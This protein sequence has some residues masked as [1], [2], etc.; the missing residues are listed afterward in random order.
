MRKLALFFL[1]AGFVFGHNTYAIHGKEAGH[2][3]NGGNC[4]SESNSVDV[5]WA[6]D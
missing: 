2:L 6:L 4:N 5:D 3:G 1:L